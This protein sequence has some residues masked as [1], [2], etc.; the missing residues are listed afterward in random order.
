[1]SVRW[2]EECR[3]IN[4]CSGGDS[5]LSSSCLCDGPGDFSTR[6]DVESVCSICAGRNEQKNRTNGRCR[7]G[8][9]ELR[10]LRSSHGFE[11]EVE[12]KIESFTG[13]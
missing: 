11:E 13:F 4:D 5:S 2:R 6:A 10:V 1:M 7:I 3:K 8:F 12:S 9:F